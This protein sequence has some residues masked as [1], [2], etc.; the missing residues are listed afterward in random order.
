M[1]DLGEFMLECD[2]FEEIEKWI[3]QRKAGN[4]S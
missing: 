2:S 3:Q 1:F 4:L